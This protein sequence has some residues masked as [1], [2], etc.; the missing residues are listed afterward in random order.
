MNKVYVEIVYQPDNGYP[1]KNYYVLS[2]EEYNQCL[3]SLDNS[4]CEINCTN[5]NIYIIHNKEKQSAIEIF[6]EHFQNNFDILDIITSSSH[7]VED[8]SE[9]EDLTD[10]INITTII[11]IALKKAVT[12][13][14]NDEVKNIIRDNIHLLFDDDDVSEYIL[15]HQIADDIGFCQ[16]LVDK[17]REK[18]DNKKVLQL[19]D[20][21]NE[22]SLLNHLLRQEEINIEFCKYLIGLGTDLNIKDASGL[23][24]LMKL[25]ESYVNEVNAMDDDLT[26]TIEMHLL[27]KYPDTRTE[28]REDFLNLIDTCL[29]DDKSTMDIHITDKRKKALEELF[30]Y[31][32]EC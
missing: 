16:E 29:E 4:D 8:I 6:L 13:H 20:S 18:W 24:V 10:S 25:K 1:Y 7:Q 3:V 26:E 31:Y 2:N 32:M 21:G 11:Q 17:I 5:T 12:Q 30:K 19:I 15:Y 9:D 28:S 23:S 27:E 14:D 22:G